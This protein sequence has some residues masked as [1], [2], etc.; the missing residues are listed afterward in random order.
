M[1]QQSVINLLES[2]AHKYPTIANQA[3]EIVILYKEK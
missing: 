2:H 3:D 1:L